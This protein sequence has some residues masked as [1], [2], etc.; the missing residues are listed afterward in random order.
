[1][2]LF[3][4]LSVEL[5][6][7]KCPAGFSTDSKSKCACQSSIVDLGLDCNMTNYKVH[8]N[9]QQWVGVTHEHTTTGES[10][11][12]IAHQHC[13]FDYCRTDNESLSICLEHQDEQCAFNRTGILCG[14]IICH[15]LYSLLFTLNFHCIAI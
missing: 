3:Q 11:G 5:K 12:V 9:K 4:E 13:P 15:G 8:R 1:M 14:S 10:S 2:L 6:V 7:N